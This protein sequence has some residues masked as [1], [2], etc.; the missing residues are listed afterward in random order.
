MV[1][2]LPIIKNWRR[3]K[4]NFR[5]FRVLTFGLLL[6]ME[7]LAFILVIPKYGP[8]NDVDLFFSV[9]IIFAFGAGLLFDRSS[10][11]SSPEKQFFTQNIIL[12]TLLGSTAFIVMHLIFLGL[13]TP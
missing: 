7:A 12:S 11:N 4:K 2:G 10:R 9:Y 13:P 3:E 6:I 5:N 1:S 8:V